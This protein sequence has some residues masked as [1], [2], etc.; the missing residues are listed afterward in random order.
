MNIFFNPSLGAS[1]VKS[2]THTLISLARPSVDTSDYSR[3]KSSEER[4]N[5]QFY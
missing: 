4:N 5:L 1:V 3:V 2:C